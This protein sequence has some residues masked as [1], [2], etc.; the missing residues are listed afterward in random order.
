VSGVLRWR[1]LVIVLFGALSVV[2]FRYTAA[3]LGIN[4]DT[5]DMISPHLAWRQDFIDYRE[6]F[7]SRYRVVLAVVDAP[8]AGQAERAAM[9][10]AKRLATRSDTFQ[11]VFYPGA[12]PFLQRNGLLYLEPDALE[13]LADRLAQVQPLLGRLQARFSAEQLI[14]VV[15]EALERADPAGREALAPLL[16]ELTRTV[17]GEDYELDWRS[18]LA[19]ADLTPAA[20]VIIVE[21]RLQ[22][23]R[24]QPARRAMEVLRGEIDQLPVDGVVVSL[25]GTVAMEHEELAS[26]TAGA[27]LAGVLALLMVS[28]VLYL[29]LRSV[30]LLGVTVMTL[31]VGLVGTA[32][33]AAASIGHLN[34]ISVAFAVL[35]IGLGVDFV[36][37]WTL[38][39]QELRGQGLAVKDALPATARGVGTSLVVCAVTTAAGF[40]SFIPTPFEG[41]SELGLISGTGMFISL[42]VSVTLLPALLCVVAP[43]A[44]V[45]QPVRWLGAELLTPLVSRPLRVVAVALLLGLAALALLPGV[46]FDNNPLNLRDP[47]AESVRSFKALLEDMAEP[48]L[49]LALL[50]DPGHGA[51]AAEQAAALPS[52]RAVRTLAD[53]IPAEQEVKL[54]ILEDMDLLLG[55]DFAELTPDPAASPAGLEAALGRLADRLAALPG[56]SASE[57]EL[58]AALAASPSHH[59]GRYLNALARRLTAGL[60]Y[61]LTRLANGLGAESFTR[62]QLP[63]ALADRWRSADGRELVEIY[64]VADITDNRTAATFLADVRSQ[65]PRATGLPV[66]HHEAGATVV[67]SFKLAFIYALAMIAVLLWGL[68]QSLRDALLVLAPIVLGALITAALTVLAGI[69]FNFANIIA[70]PLLLGVGVDNGVHMVHRARTEPVAGGAL[71]TSTSRAVLFSGLTTL[72]SFGNLGFSPHPGMASMGQLLAIGM[73]LTLAA[74]L[75]L[76]PALLRLRR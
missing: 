48:P 69:A 64:P 10:L 54:F 14:A 19:S 65:L 17:A 13:A 43:L 73:A 16:T 75:V 47:D 26:V 51:A 62:Q 61:E 22:F 68:L 28:A 44:P 42:F 72:A 49:S 27:A 52:V 18:L 36:I 60:P 35:Y 41:V 66:V 76:L 56:V 8:T 50:A 12:E 15:D 29:A 37:H 30:A 39:F 67:K 38:R 63:A 6:S 32:A 33:F 31:L 4:T 59:E 46:R 24:V 70:L 53:L 11:S 7:P 40:Y 71:A 5:A 23:D 55:P 34:L 1:W 2:S 25:T 21:P 57:R 58:A 74:T 3:H 45:R 9:A 20:Q